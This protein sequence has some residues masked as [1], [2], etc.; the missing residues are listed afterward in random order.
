MVRFLDLLQHYFQHEGHFLRGRF[1]KKRLVSRLKELSSS[2]N[3]RQTTLSWLFSAHTHCKSYFHQFQISCK[4]L[5]DHWT[6][7]QRGQEP[8]CTCPVI[9]ILTE[10]LNTVL[11]LIPCRHIVLYLFISFHG[12]ATI[13]RLLKI[14]GLL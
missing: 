1:R 6:T 10:H 5:S 14:V 9:S 3:W 4:I 13:S 8:F 11:R 12:L 7:S 2:C